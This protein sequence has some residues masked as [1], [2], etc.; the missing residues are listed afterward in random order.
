MSFN[1]RYGTAKD[2]ANHWDMRK[3]LVFEVIAKHSPDVLGLQEALKFQIDEILAKSDHY[4]M[5]G[6]GRDR[7]GRGEHAALLYK[8]ELFDLL[9]SGTFWLSDTPE[10]RSRDWGNSIVRITTWVKLKD[11]KTGNIFYVYNAHYDHE[12]QDSREKG[13]QLI[14]SKIATQSPVIVMGDLNA[15]ESNKAI[16]PLAENLIDS[17]RAIHPTTKR[18]GTFN[19]WK[20]TDTEDKIDY[21]FVSKD[22]TVLDADIIRDNK[23]G[24]YPS[25]H[26]PV[27]ATIK[28][29]P[30]Q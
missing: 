5:I 22:I 19:D 8:A 6:R 2:G 7:R 10:K 3:D 17:Y 15:G 28:L 4:K 27:T 23:N 16:T 11:K 1:I 26:F 20:G 21:V 9:D 13:T 14:L 29:G 12:S 30:M 18:V 24:R 25:D